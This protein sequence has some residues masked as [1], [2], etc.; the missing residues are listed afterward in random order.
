[1]AQ[2]EAIKKIKADLSPD[3][4]ATVFTKDLDGKDLPTIINLAMEY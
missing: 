4:I 2:I 3:G 1:M